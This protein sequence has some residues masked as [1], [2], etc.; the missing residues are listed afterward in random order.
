MLVNRQRFT[1][2]SRLIDLEECTLGNNSTI[3]WDD[4][5]LYGLLA[6]L[7]RTFSAESLSH[8]FN[9][10]NITGDDFCSVDLK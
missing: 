1:G 2:Y 8:L 4:R 9:L 5:A 6:Y 3:S 10:Q 7:P